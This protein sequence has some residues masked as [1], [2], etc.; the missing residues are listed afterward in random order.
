M[1]IISHAP[2]RKF[3]LT[4]TFTVHSQIV[5]LHYRFTRFMEIFVHFICT[6]IYL[7]IMYTY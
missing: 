3:Q 4:V 5:G 2:S 6:F 7:V 1:H